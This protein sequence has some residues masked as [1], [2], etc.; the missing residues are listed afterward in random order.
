[1]VTTRVVSYRRIAWGSKDFGVQELR[2]RWKK[3]DGT[4]LITKLETIKSLT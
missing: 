2:F 4:W 3:I 1:M